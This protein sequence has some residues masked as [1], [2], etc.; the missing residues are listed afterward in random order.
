[1]R[2][3]VVD[4]SLEHSSLCLIRQSRST[5]ITPG[6]V[7]AWSRHCNP[8]ET[9]CSTSRKKTKQRRSFVFWLQQML[10]T[11]ANVIKLKLSR[12]PRGA[13]GFA[14]RWLA[15][16]E[17]FGYGL[18]QNAEERL[19]VEKKAINISQMSRG[20]V[21]E[22]RKTIFLFRFRRLVLTSQMAFKK[23]RCLTKKFRAKFIL[24]LDEE[25]RNGKLNQTNIVLTLMQYKNSPWFVCIQTVIDTFNNFAW[26]IAILRFWTIFLSPLSTWY[27]SRHSR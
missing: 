6:V 10:A 19:V 11:A 2:L 7:P 3:L 12:H 1:M 13:C 26:N 18:T 15:S 16:E 17:S 21:G 8:V 5:G 9:K 25:N 20:F 27:G 23:K 22:R 4:T 24:M 14:E